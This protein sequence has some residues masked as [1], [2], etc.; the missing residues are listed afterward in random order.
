MRLFKGDNLYVNSYMEK[1]KT[2]VKVRCV[3][4]GHVCD[5]PRKSI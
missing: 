4:N 2:V 3:P 1:T 5:D